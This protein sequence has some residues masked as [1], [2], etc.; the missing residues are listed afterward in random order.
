MF[1][2][3][4]KTRSTMLEVTAFVLGKAVVYIAVGILVF[5]VGDQI[6]HALVPL[7]V[8]VRKLLGPLFLLTGL[9]MIEWIRL[10][11]GF[12]IQVSNILKEKVNQLGGARSNFLLGIAFSLGWCPS[13]VLLFFGLLVPLMIS[14]PSGLLLPPVFA[15]GTALPVILMTLLAFAVGIDKSFILRSRRIGRIIQ[16]VAGLVF[17]LIGLNDVLAYW[18]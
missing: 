15:I 13:M 9:L 2:R 7:Y 10:P 12:G 16:K 3:V 6:S 17:I 8:F 18:L 14:E 11:S 5:V 1:N 4:E